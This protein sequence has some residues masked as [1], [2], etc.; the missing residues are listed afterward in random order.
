MEEKRLEE[1]KQLRKQL[2]QLLAQAR[3]NEQTQSFFD[4]FSLAVVA[5]QG[6]QDLFNLILDEQ[7][8]FRVDEIR[9][10]LVDRFH[11][12]ERLLTESYQNAYNGLSFIDTETCNLLISDI[13]DR[14]MLGT[15]IIDKYS[16]LID[17]EETN[18]YRSAAL[19][20]LKRG[21]EIIGIQLL[22]SKNEARYN[23]ND[24]TTFLQKLSAMIA[25]S[26]ENCINRQRTLELGYQDG[27]TNA[28]NRRY[29]DERLKH[30]VDRCTRN[31]TD[32][33]CLFLDVDFFKKV[34]DQHGHQ[35]GDAVLIRLVAL[36]R[37]QVR[38]SDI[39]ARYGGEEFAVILPD[40]GIQLAR[41]VAERIRSKVETQKLITDDA[42]LSITVS[43]GLAS[44][45]QLRYQATDVLQGGVTSIEK[46]KLDQQLLKR[47]DEALYQ[48]K[49]MGRNCVV[50]QKMAC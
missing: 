12:V 34:N 44:L 15:R 14:P 29:F 23:K 10:C 40:T 43:I 33:V 20:P 16:W 4:D 3:R 45:S 39:V 27:L 46:E 13:P 37:E 49:Q 31:K 5:A 32:L 30:E 11:E 8:K 42:T 25:I 21:K 6:P 50:I 2:E 41:E 9:L 24:G 35:V 38:S 7:K 36:M 28:Y 22:L 26:I 18:K 1:N 19:L 48:A 47:A 17:I